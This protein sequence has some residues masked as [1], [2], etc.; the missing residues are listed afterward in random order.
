[1][2]NFGEGIDIPQWIIKCVR[3][4]IQRLRVARSRHNR[5]RADEA[6]DVLVVVARP[7]VVDVTGRRLVALP[8]EAVVRRQHRRE[9]R[10]A[11]K[12]LV[13]QAAGRPTVRIGRQARRAEMI[14][15]ACQRSDS[16]LAE[17][18][19]PSAPPTCPRGIEH[20]VPLR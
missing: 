13:P 1:M 4:S 10:R 3:I 5:I 19:W 16:G 8:G 2:L 11:P 7:V 17:E 15:T 20:G 18:C 6:P 12:R 9:P 14:A